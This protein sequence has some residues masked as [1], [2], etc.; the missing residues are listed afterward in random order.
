MHGFTYLLIPSKAKG[1]VA[2]TTANMSMRKVLAY[3]RCSTKKIN[4][5][6]SVLFDACSNGKNI[7]IKDDILRV[8]LYLINE[9]V[10]S[11]LAN[12]YSSFVRIRLAIF[13]KSH[14]HNGRAIPLH[15]LSL[16][17]KLFHATFH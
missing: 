14:H 11:S 3:P 6:I 1:N 10:V 16:S 17:D 5:V 15:Q 8:K 9:D 7:G 13:I 4:C 2:H 12:R